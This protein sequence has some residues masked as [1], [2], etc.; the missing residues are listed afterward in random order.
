MTTRRRKVQTGISDLATPRR[1]R[2]PRPAT[3]RGTVPATRDGVHLA[4]RTWRRRSNR[5][6]RT[7]RR[8]GKTTTVTAYFASIG[9][10]MTDIKDVSVKRRY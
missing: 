9:Q 7:R 2:R 8:L 4:G 6:H 3:G 1:P 10:P 5:H